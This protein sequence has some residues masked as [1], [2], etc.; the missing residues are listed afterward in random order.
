MSDDRLLSD[1]ARLARKEGR[2]EE[3]RLDER[4][5][6]LAAGTLT[7]EEEAKLRALAESSPEAREA[8]E[9]FRPL[10]VEFEARMV[11]AAAAQLRRPRPR[12]LPFRRPAARIWASL[13][14]AGA[15]AASMLLLFRPVALRPLPIYVAELKGGVQ[16]TRGGE[17]PGTSPQ[18]FVPGSLL[19]L[20]VRPREALE[21]E[22]EAMSFLSQ[23]NEVVVWEPQPPLEISNGAVRLRGTLGQE[24]H[25]PA[26]DWRVW[27]VVH[28]PGK[29]PSRAEF[30]AQLRAG[31]A[32]HAG[33]LAVS[34]DLR[35]Q[36]QPT[37]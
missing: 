2:S 36:D 11:A 16:D 19:T 1:L 20:E 13:G 31:P 14:A 21:G 25:L 23:G 34:V 32:Q 29:T 5:D 8:Y 15:V 9:A 18:V 35:V 22:V 24:I 17:V 12:L 10:G 3:E 27:I 30:L 4:W 33:W 28:R 26:G 7:A 37:P 6:R